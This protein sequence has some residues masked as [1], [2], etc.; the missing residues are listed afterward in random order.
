[1]TTRASPIIH[2]EVAPGFE[3]V[4]SAFKRNFIQGAELGAAW[5]LWF[6]F[7]SEKILRE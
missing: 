2:G 5:R 3:P 4:R 1:M 7:D 6:S